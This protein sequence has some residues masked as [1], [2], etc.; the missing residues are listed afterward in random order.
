MSAVNQ[1]IKRHRRAEKELR[2]RAANFIKDQSTD[3]V[4]D[5][6][7]SVRRM[8]AIFDLLPKR[9]QKE[10]KFKKYLSALRKFFKSTTEI[11]DLD[12]VRQNLESYS[13]SP[14]V[15]EAIQIAVRERNHLVPTSLQLGESFQK[16]NSPKIRKKDL[17]AK[18]LTKRRDKILKRLTAKLQEELP[19]VLGDYRKIRELHDM[20]KECKRL[21]YTLELLPSRKESPLM[22]RMR[23]WQ[24]VL[25]TIRDIDVTQQFAEKKGLLEDLE[26]VLASLRITRS[27]M[28]ES[29]SKSVK[30][31]L[32]TVP[33]KQ[34]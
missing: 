29:F 15:A 5:L 6:R 27:K 30:P 21:R 16:T 34:R 4:H 9:V 28:L 26:E 33:A 24:S 8:E 10:R 17:S 14:Q 1:I 13:S 11:R 31:E 3:N 23:D 7:T 32:Q 25:G 18:R 20:R 12:V 2:S 19:I 22:A